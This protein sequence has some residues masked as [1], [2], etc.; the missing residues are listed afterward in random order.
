MVPF[1]SKSVTLSMSIDAD[2][3]LYWF[4]RINL[5]LTSKIG[6]FFWGMLALVVP[7]SSF[8]AYVV[9]GGLRGSTMTSGPC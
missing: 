4:D 6:L 9:I 1:G 3:D 8:G 2:E 7:E 5:P